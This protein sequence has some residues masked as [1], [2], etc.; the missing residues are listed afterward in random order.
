MLDLER[1]WCGG[2]VRFVVYI[3]FGFIVYILFGFIVYILFG[4]IVYILFGFVVYIMFLL[5]ERREMGRK[6]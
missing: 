2:E 5:F 3:L 4:F 6:G 1:G